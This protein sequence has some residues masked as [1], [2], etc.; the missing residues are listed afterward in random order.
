MTN[1]QTLGRASPINSPA[2]A[3]LHRAK[4]RD[5][6]IQNELPSVRE[7]AVLWL[8][9]GTDKQ[10]G[11]YGLAI[12]SSIAES[13]GGSVTLSDGTLY[14][15]LKRLRRKGYIDLYKG[16]ADGGGANRHYFYLTDQGRV[17]VEEFNGYFGSLRSMSP[18]KDSTD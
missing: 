2:K 3:T 10:H 9:E 14:S 8:L 11:F 1:S 6:K 18:G 4:I 16:C 17:A 12:Q 5:Q 15:L 13:S 7:L